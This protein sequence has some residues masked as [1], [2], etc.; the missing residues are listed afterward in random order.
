M[1]MHL[2]FQHFMRE[3]VSWIFTTLLYC[4]RAPLGTHSSV[5]SGTLRIQPALI[6]LN[7]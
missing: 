1:K 4:K 5:A 2:M 6:A 3:Q 7:A